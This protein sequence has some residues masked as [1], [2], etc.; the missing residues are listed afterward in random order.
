MKFEMELNDQQMRVIID[1]IEL[2]SRLHI[3]QFTDLP[4][5]DNKRITFEEAEQIKNIVFPEL[6]RGASYSI[7]SNDIK[8]SGNISWD[9]YQSFRQE[10]FWK[11]D[12][13]DW[14]VDDR[15]WPA[16]MQVFYDTPYVTSKYPLPTIKMDDV[17]VN[18]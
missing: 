7:T 10:Y 2:Y 11:K 3:G 1:A 18:N 16:M 14:R 9:L 12:G 8:D 5:S 13:K 17:E 4:T 6:S 15:D